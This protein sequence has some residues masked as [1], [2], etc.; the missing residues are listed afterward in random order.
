MMS[1]SLELAAYRALS[2]R[3][4]ERRFKPK[5]QRP[6]GAVL[7]VH[8]AEP[9]AMLALEDL[10]LRILS[11]RPGL[12]IL[13]TLP[14]NENFDQARNSWTQRDDICFELVPSEHPDAVAAFWAHWRPDMCVWTWGQLR[15]NLLA[16]AHKS[17]CP[18]ILI[19][20]DSGGFEGRRDRWLPELSRQLLEPC[21]A[22]MVRIV[23]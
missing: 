7:W 3:S 14:S 23:T 9:D 19:D 2:R 10:M 1:R 11:S 20:A 12:N 6:T 18:V 13:V 5:N 22:M 21:A 17:G 8:A 4:F 15:P 16:Q